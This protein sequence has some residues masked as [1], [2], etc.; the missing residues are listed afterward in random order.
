MS[1]R[2]HSWVLSCALVLLTVS[3][4]SGAGTPSLMSY[5]G[6]LTD[7][8]GSSL[9][10][11]YSLVFTIYDD[12]VASAPG[13]IMW[14]ETHP[15]VTVTGGLFSV[16]FGAG[17]PAV[18]L[19]ES[20]FSSPDRYLGIKVG[21]DPEISPRTRLVSTP[22]A[23]ASN[24]WAFRITDTADT[25]LT[26][27]GPWGLTRDGN[28]LLGTADSTHVNLGVASTTGTVG[29]DNKYCT[30]GG[31]IANTASG[32]SATVGGGEHNMA[33]GDQAT[34]GG[35]IWNAAT[36][37]RATVAGGENNNAWGQQATV[38]GGVNNTASGSGT[39]V[40]GGFFNSADNPSATV[41][42]GE[43]N[44]ASGFYATIPGGYKDTAAGD[45]SLAA[46]SM[47]RLTSDAEKT[48]A[49]G[50]N[51]TA[52]ASHAVIFHDADTPIK[53]GI[54]TTSPTTTLHVQGDA[55]VKSTGGSVSLSGSDG[56]MEVWGTDGAFIDLKDS[57]S[58]DY[59]V[60]ITQIFG[61][62]NLSLLGGNIGIG[63]VSPQAKLDIM[64]TVA[65]RSM[66][67]GSYTAVHVDGNGLLYRATSSRRYKEDIR[68]LTIDPGLALKL[69]PVQFR[70]KE[71][72]ANDIGLIAE[73]VDRVIPEVVVRDADG[74]PDAVQY[75]KL[76]LFLLA[77]LKEQS[78]TI[79]QMKT[80]LRAVQQQKTAEID[81]LKAQITHL[82][83]VVETVLTGQNR[84]TG[85]ND[86][87]T[88]LR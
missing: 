40:A 44:C 60:R 39:T 27:R 79:E 49:F 5:Q 45:F 52:S 25:S 78:N 46:G 3:L 63:T 74:R 14:Q 71:S 31:G 29:Q 12:P 1:H 35:G 87:L 38:G 85:G 28:T 76:T 61:T 51:F 24:H 67:T 83:T 73:D 84:A 10:G 59:D 77:T 7:V 37:I 32:P 34:V 33:S 56:S 4:A 62:S 21:A 81:S 48:F 19:N 41:G 86:E 16:V 9:D 82:Q 50:N 58:D 11:S 2:L 53:V 42:G 70:W 69:Q 64:G 36:N 72:G 23:F 22:Y 54:G 20:V 66:P 30:V 43:F 80:E 6:R 68:A 13:N 18:S 88:N 15:S 65:V 57:E 17:T 26:T 47:V 55:L 75:D 8:G